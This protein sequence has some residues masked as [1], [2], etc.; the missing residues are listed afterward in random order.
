MEFDKSIIFE[1]FNVLWLY[2]LKFML[3]P[4]NKGSYSSKCR[5]LL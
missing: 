5:T 2:V 1:P 3:A 4:A